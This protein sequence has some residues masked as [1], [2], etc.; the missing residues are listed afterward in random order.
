MGVT[1]DIVTPVEELVE[2]FNILN[3]AGEE[4]F[5]ALRFVS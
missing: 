3:A 2:V 4:M 5:M 1:T